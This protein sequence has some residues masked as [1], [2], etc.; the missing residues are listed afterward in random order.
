VQVIGHRGASGLAP[1][2]TL[3][4]FRLAAD[5]GAHFIETDLQLTRDGRVVILHD[6]TLRRT[7]DGRGR[8]AGKTFEQLR[9]LDAGSWF[10]KRLLRRR[11]TPARFAGERIPCIEELFELA[12][13]RDLGLYLEMKTPCAPGA[14]R[15]VV[16]AIRAAK[17]EVRSTV[18][19]FDLAVLQRVRKLAPELAVGLL[20]NK[21]MPDAVARAASVRASAILPHAGRVTPRV[22]TEAKR[23]GMQVVTWTVND[24]RK[25][26]KLM[27]MGVDGIMSDFPERVAAVARGE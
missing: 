16:A 8:L 22:I 2:N 6:G 23:L 24:P 27:A 18:I 25:M 20:F 19:C 17:A 1:E 13:E 11:R 14:E 26:R 12:Q 7:T 9:K 10:P 15:A 4:A 5:L 3:A 21:R